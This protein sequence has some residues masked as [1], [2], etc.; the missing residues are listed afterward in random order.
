MASLNDLTFNI[1]IQQADLPHYIKLVVRRLADPMFEYWQMMHRHESIGRR[2][3]TIIWDASLKLTE[4]KYFDLAKEG[5]IFE[6]QREIIEQSRQAAMLKL[7]GIIPVELSVL[8]KSN[9]FCDYYRQVKIEE[10]LLDECWKSYRDRIE[11]LAQ[12]VPLSVI[13][14]HATADEA[15]RPFKT[16]G[17]DTLLKESEAVFA[18]FRTEQFTLEQAV[19]LKRILDK[20]GIKGIAIKIK[21]TEERESSKK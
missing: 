13:T 14:I 15:E 1:S 7:V 21:P 11:A 9:W 5:S 18:R 2:T 6:N 3:P 17:Y 16:A 19:G 12:R 20:H 8:N 4:Y 10:R